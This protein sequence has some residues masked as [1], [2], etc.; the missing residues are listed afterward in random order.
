MLAIG[1]TAYAVA[2]VAGAMIAGGAVDRIGVG[3]VAR[4]FLFPMASARAGSAIELCFFWSGP[5]R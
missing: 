4:L 2:S 5:C 1:M 3:R